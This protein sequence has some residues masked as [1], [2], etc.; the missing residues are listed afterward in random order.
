M[1]SVAEAQ[2]FY[3]F[4]EKPLLLN[5]LAREVKEARLRPEETGGIPWYYLSGTGFFVKTQADAFFAGLKKRTRN[6]EYFTHAFK[7]EFN[8][9][10]VDIEAFEDEY[11]K[12]MAGLK[13]NIGFKEMQGKKRIVATGQYD[14]TLLEEITD[15]SEREGAVYDLWFEGDRSCNIPAIEKWLCEA[16]K[17]SLAVIVSPAGWSGLF[18]PDNKP[19]RFPETQIYVASIDEKGELSAYT[20]RSNADIEKN[21]KLQKKL[22]LKIDSASNQKER[23]KRVLKNVAF[24]RGDDRNNPVKSVQD[25]V[26]ILE[27]IN[28][29]PVAFENKTFADIRAFLSSPEKFLYHHP[30]MPSLLLDL[31]N[32]VRSELAQGHSERETK[33]NFQVGLALTILKLNKLYRQQEG[34]SVIK[35]S[36]NVIYEQATNLHSYNQR[37]PGIPFNGG[38]KLDIR[39][40]IEDLRK[41]GGCAGGGTKDNKTGKESG[42]YNSMGSSRREEINTSESEGNYG[43]DDIDICAACHEGPKPVGPCK[44]CEPCDAKMG[45]K[46]AG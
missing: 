15:K 1:T 37:M 28:E 19:I 40:E 34:N 46:G 23:I 8:K 38:S 30:E 12:Q 17:K 36:E 45:G 26:D 10:K 14:N 3:N 42:R 11:L 25:V 4:Q 7:R 33:T 21:E 22:G 43:F 5:P 27:E 9:V 31:E 24:L 13:W 41:K 18:T 2:R 44:I 39:S 6:G 20:F 29:S 32:F 16:P 35:N